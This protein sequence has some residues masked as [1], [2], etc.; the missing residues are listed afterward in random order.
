MQ[1][2][3]TDLL[4]EVDPKSRI[5][6]EKSSRV[7]SKKKTSAKRGSGDRRPHRRSSRNHSNSKKPSHAK[8]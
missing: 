8:E 1:P 5:R 4:A 2:V 6:R 7:S 3:T